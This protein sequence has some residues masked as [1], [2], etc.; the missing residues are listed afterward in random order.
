MRQ[1]LNHIKQEAKLHKNKGRLNRER[2]VKQNKQIAKWY[3][4]VYHEERR[5]GQ[6]QQRMIKEG[7]KER[8][9]YHKL[10]QNKQLEAEIQDRQLIQIKVQEGLDEQIVHSITNNHEHIG[11]GRQDEHKVNI[12]SQSRIN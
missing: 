7:A 12:Q 3:R 1:P 4:K 10:A 5:E 2:R 9:E 11:Q 8:Q 6:R